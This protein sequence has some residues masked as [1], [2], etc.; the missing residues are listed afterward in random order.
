VDK[1][2]AADLL[3]ETILV[4]MYAEALWILLQWC[5]MKCQSCLISDNTQVGMT[6]KVYEKCDLL[7]QINIIVHSIH[8]Y[9]EMMD[10]TCKLELAI[11]KVHSC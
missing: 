3:L 2:S 11:S 5:L 7:L 1:E 9:V 6:T 4:G 8:H 10:M